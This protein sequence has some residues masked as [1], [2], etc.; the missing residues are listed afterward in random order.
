MQDCKGKGWGR[1]C[2]DKSIV[3]PNLAQVHGEFLLKGTRLLY[4]CTQSNV[5]LNH[6]HVA[7]T[8]PNGSHVSFTLPM[9]NNAHVGVVFKPFSPI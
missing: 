9:C 6:L 1:S 2:C 4:L 3:F 7:V 8:N 5:H